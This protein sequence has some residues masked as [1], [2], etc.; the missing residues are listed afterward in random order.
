[1]AAP[2][3]IGSTVTLEVTLTDPDSGVAVDAADITCR[4]QQPDGSA[5]QAVA[6]VTKFAAGVYRARYPIAMAGDHWFEFASVTL[7]MQREGVFAA[8]ASHVT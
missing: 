5:V 4:V 1:M 8:R 7:G 3:D 6:P 2:F